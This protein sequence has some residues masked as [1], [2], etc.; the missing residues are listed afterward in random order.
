LF[1]ASGLP[2]SDA[3]W[4][5]DRA[6]SIV[7]GNGY[8]FDGVP[9][10]FWPV[11]Y[12]GFLALLFSIFPET[13][14]TGLIANF[15]L[16][17][18]TAG[19][20]LRIFRELPV[21]AAFAVFG[22][23]VLVVFPEFVFYQD[24]LV[25]ETLM[26]AALSIALLAVILARRNYQF[27]LTGISFGLAT[28]VKSQVLF[29]P[30]LPFIYDLWYHPGPRAILRKYLLLAIG[31]F[32]VI[33]PWTMRNYVVFH[34]FILVQSNGGYNLLMGYNEHN[35]WGG[36]TGTASE[37][38]AMFPGIVADI[39]RP[40]PDEMGM[41]DR[42]TAMALGFMISNTVEVLKRTPY[43]L[44]RFFR[45]DPQGVGALLRS[46][47]AAGNH[48]SWLLSLCTLSFW[49]YTVVMALAMLSWIAFFLPPLQNRAHFI[50][51]STILYFATISAA[52]FGEGRFHIP[53]L[54]AFVGCMLVTLQAA[55]L[56]LWPSRLPRTPF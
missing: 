41:N 6:V 43:K 15:L 5:F 19:C 49:Y 8:A 18:I 17:A 52:F 27:L 21:S 24:L 55:K 12:P 48:P 42:A 4:Y 51:L 22:L 56:T 38:A 23:L 50:L 14:E 46:N 34:R 40:L 25:T 11:G 1:T 30:V 37:F 33:S 10:A 47:A 16:A 20:S 36:S 28:V 45:P 32:V 29:L 2:V 35:R 13:P 26:T 39:N 44:Y 9:T 7:H 31:M 3:K 54:P 53:I